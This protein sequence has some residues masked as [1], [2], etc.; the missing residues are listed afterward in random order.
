MT[1]RGLL[2]KTL[3]PQILVNCLRY[4]LFLISKTSAL[5]TMFWNVNDNCDVDV[6]I[7]RAGYQSKKQVGKKLLFRF[8]SFFVLG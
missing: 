7:D 3:L 4:Q 2:R 8:F 6:A 1:I 5:Q